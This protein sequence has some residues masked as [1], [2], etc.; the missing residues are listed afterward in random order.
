MEWLEKLKVGDLVLMNQSLY[1]NTM[2]VRVIRITKTQ[3]VCRKMT[4]TYE[5]KFRKS[6]GYMVGSDSFVR[7]SIIPATKENLE[8]RE[9]R[10]RLHAVK[11]IDI[12]SL[13]NVQI[14]EI[15]KIIKG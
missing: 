15:Y 8:H 11:N 6:D 5:I 3:I 14:N 7:N 10:K 13:T 1:Y 9:Y 12:N 2:K 4:D